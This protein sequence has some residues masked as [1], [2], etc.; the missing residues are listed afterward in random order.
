MGWNLVDTLFALYIFCFRLCSINND[1]DFETS[2]TS[3]DYAQTPKS[4]IVQGVYMVL[5]FITLDN[6]VFA[7]SPKL[8][9]MWAQFKSS[10]IN[11]CCNHIVYCYEH[12]NIF[13][14]C[15]PL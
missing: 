15:S 10:S 7:C 14:H 5:V 4:F 3:D 13:P 9:C 11:V 2:P 1:K 8:D 12:V 6:N